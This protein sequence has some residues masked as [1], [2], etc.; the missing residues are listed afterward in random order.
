V[1]LTYLHLVFLLPE[2]YTFL[3]YV[4]YDNETVILIGEDSN[5]KGTVILFSLAS[6]SIMDKY[7]FDESEL[8]QGLLYINVDIGWEYSY[9]VRDGK[10]LVFMHRGRIIGNYPGSASQFISAF[11]FNED[12]FFSLTTTGLYAIFIC[13][14]L[15]KYCRI[16]GKIF[17]EWNF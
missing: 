11:E 15:T 17:C 8:D 12:L 9:G 7:E 3:S 2:E 6:V 10:E 14:I 16:S 13:H 5:F 4:Y 1:S